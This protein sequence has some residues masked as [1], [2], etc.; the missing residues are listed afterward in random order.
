[1]GTTVLAVILLGLIP[2]MGRAEA[3]R[4]ASGF[5]I[6]KKVPSDQPVHYGGTLFLGSKAG[7]VWLEYDVGQAKP[8]YLAHDLFVTEIKF[9]A[10]F[11]ADFTTDKHVDFYKGVQAQ[12]AAAAQQSPALANAANAAVKAIQAEVDH[13]EKGSVR[14]KGSWVDREKHLA[15]ANAEEQARMAAV[16]AS[17]AKDEAA[18]EEMRGKI[19]KRK[20]AERVL[21]RNL[22]RSYVSVP[23]QNLIQNFESM[24]K[25]ATADAGKFRAL[26]GYVQPDLAQMIALPQNGVVTPM[27]QVLGAADSDSAGAVLYTYNADMTQLI[28]ADI[29]LHIESSAPGQALTTRSKAEVDGVRKVL[30]PFDARIFDCIPDVLAAS[31]IM[32]ALKDAPASDRGTPFNRN[33]MTGYRVVIEVFDPQDLE[34]RHILLVLITIRPAA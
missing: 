33:D 27:L 32:A 28:G 4:F 16:A 24:V 21:Q 30:D 20:A 13:Y 15:K 3:P 6:Y 31:R 9:G 5:V 7:P 19:E 23:A 8:F 29:A 34:N 11:E 17:K 25:S 12:L 18:Q 14:I 26:P 10:L 1:M 2:G 22:S